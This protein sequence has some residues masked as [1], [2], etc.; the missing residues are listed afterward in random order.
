MTK[1][2]FFAYPFEKLICRITFVYKFYRLLDILKEF[3][4]IHH[5]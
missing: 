2:L 1:P 3:K 5:Q 4:S